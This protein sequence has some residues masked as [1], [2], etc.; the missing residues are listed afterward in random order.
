MK[1]YQLYKSSGE[2]WIGEIPSSWEVKR[3]GQLFVQRSETVSDSDFVPLSVSKN[4]IVPQMDGVS[5]TENN[6]SRKLVKKGDFVINSRSDRKGSSGFST[7][8]GSVSVINIV[9]KPK[10]I[11]PK[12]SHYLFRSYLFVE[13]FF[14]NG[15]GIVMDLWSTRFSEMKYINIPYPPLS[16]QHQIVQFLDKKNELIDKLIS[17]TKTRI[18]ILKEGIISFYEFKK[19]GFDYYEKDTFWFQKKPKSWEVIKFKDLFE[20]ISEKNHPKERL[21][22]VH[23][24]KGVIYRDEQ[25]NNVMNPIGDLSSYKLIQPGDFVISLRSSEGGFEYSEIKGLVSPIYTVLRPKYPIDFIFYKFLFKSK[26]FIIELNRYITG[27]RD[28]KS[29]YFDDIK[30]IPIPVSKK[31]NQEILKKHIIKTDLFNLWE[32]RNKILNEYRQSLISEVVTGKIN[33]TTDE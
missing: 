9:L 21:V 3:V 16:E 6:D 15:K 7:L 24:I 31:L 26:N 33:V 23:Q 1:K 12:F 11:Y 5:K 30:N 10:N 22:T 17:T 18:E 2:E 32:M 20:V 8:D 28:G 4:G 29:I 19:E 14:R 27:I 25:E 13:E